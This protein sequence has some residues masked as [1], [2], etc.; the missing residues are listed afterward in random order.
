MTDPEPV[1][2][3]SLDDFYT[4]FARRAAGMTPIREM[5]LEEYQRLW[6]GYTPSETADWYC[7]RIEP[8]TCGNCGTE[9]S[10]YTHPG[11]GG[12]HWIVVWPANDDPN[13][14]A[15]IGKHDGKAAI[16]PYEQALGPSISYYA[17][18]PS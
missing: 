15:V 17:I 18:H 5:D 9:F 13:M 16:V 10:H 2:L 4:R 12:E 11:G 8:W 6:D 7:L 3:G 1:I 14:Y